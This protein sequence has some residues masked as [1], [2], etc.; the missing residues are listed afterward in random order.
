MQIKGSDSFLPNGEAIWGRKLDF[1][2]QEMLDLGGG[3]GGECFSL[4]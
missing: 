3:A 4:P 1:E 2:Q